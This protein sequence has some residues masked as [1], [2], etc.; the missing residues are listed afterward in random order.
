VHID[1]NGATDINSL[2]G[3]SLEDFNHDANGASENN[4]IVGRTL[5]G[6]MFPEHHSDGEHDFSGATVAGAPNQ[7]A[8]DGY[9]DQLCSKEDYLL[10]ENTFK[11]FTAEESPNAP[12]QAMATQ[13]LT[14]FGNIH[15]DAEPIK[16]AD[17]CILRQIATLATYVSGQLNVTDSDIVSV[18]S[19]PEV[20]AGIRELQDACRAYKE[21]VSDN[22]SPEA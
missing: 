9:L 11:N 6:A 4:L 13:P 7:A 8:H 10:L 3:L 19:T 14:T 22:L 2:A 15:D 12:P 17:L 18:G 21:P 5:T 20:C 16:K 1:D